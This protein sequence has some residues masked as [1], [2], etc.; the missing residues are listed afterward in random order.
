MPIERGAEFIDGNRV[1]V[2]HYLER[3]GLQAQPGLGMRGFR[4]VHRDRLHHPLWL[5]TRPSAF[6]LALAVSSLV[7][8]Q[9]PDQSAADFLRARGVAGVGWRLAEVMANAA[10]AP[11]EDL[12]VV[13]AAAGLNSP[14]AS[15]GDFRPTGGY[16]ML[17]DSIGAR[18]GH[19]LRGA[20]HRREMEPGRGGS[21]SRPSS[22]RPRRGHH[23]APRRPPGGDRS[24]RAR[25]TRRQAA[26]RCRSQDAPGGEDPLA[27]PTPCRQRPRARHRRRRRGAGVLARSRAGAGVDGIRDRPARR[28]ARVRAGSRSR[29]P[30]FIP[31]YGGPECPRCGRGGRLGS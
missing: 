11:L 8:R 27:L 17:V 18:P 12:G 4:F 13:D 22:A 3:F 9:C 15:G 31:W 14:Q 2:W 21:R 20:S 23:P 7:R 30:L 5:L 1:R 6:R 25:L 19:S 26:G 28:H 29:A 10:C 24:L 16:Q